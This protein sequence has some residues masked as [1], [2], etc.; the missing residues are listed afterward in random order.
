MIFIKNELC[1]FFFGIPA[2]KTGVFLGI[3]Q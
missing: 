1:I 3:S 2:A